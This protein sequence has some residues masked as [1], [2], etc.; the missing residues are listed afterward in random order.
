MVEAKLNER[1]SYVVRGKEG[2]QGEKGTTST[3]KIVGRLV[4]KFSFMNE[5]TKIFKGGTVFNGRAIKKEVKVW[6]TS[7]FRREYFPFS[8]RWVYS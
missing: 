4:I 1:L 2:R 6:G 3:S 5:G 8:F 7:V